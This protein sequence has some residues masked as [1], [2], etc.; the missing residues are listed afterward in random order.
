MNVYGRETIAGVPLGLSRDY[1]YLPRAEAL[2]SMQCTSCYQTYRD[3][4]RLEPE[5]GKV[6]TQRCKLCR[7]EGRDRWIAENRPV[8]PTAVARYRQ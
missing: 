1:D 2:R 8:L 3:A 7:E 6:L 4:L 5:G